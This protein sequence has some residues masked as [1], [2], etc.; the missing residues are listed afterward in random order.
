M[1]R[2]AF[3]RMALATL[4]A[5]AAAAGP[6]AAQF[7]V[8]GPDGS[9]TYTDRQPPQNAGAR[10]TSLGRD[11]RAAEPAA[12][13]LP[14]ELRQV[15]QRFPVTLYT[16][17]ECAPCESGRRLLQQRGIPL[18]E[19]LIAND[20]DAEA[21]TRLTGARTVPALTIGQQA[22]RGFSEADWHNYLD[23][24]G[25]PK[26]SRLPKD[27]KPPQATPLVARQPEPVQVPALPQAT[28][29]GAQAAR[30]T[31]E[32]PPAQPGGIRF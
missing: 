30:P 13:P 15:A 26:E 12:P 20:D 4:A 11:A 31:P 8:V 27:W 10:V 3:R 29:P 28:V 14:L 5:L 25:Y 22:L 6:A 21:L 18:V 23:A 7:K 16:S 32:L 1:T 9:V 17:A 2:L 19:R 24:A